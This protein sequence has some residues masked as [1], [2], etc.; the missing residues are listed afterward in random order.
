MTKKFKSLSDVLKFYNI[1][2]FEANFVIVKTET[3]HEVMQQDI[4]FT[5]KEIPYDISE[6]AI[7][8]NLIYPL[9]KEAWKL[10]ANVLMLWS[11]QALED[12]TGNIRIPDYLISKR[13]SLGKIIFDF[14]LL[15]V[16]EAKKDNFSLGWTQC[17][18]D[19]IKI[20][21]LNKNDNIDIYGLV[22]N[23][24][25]WE[26]AKLSNQQF[27]VYNKRFFIEELETLFNMLV[28]VLELCKQ[29]LIDLNLR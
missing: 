9:L 16:I 29:Q 18:L 28:S 26:V 4:M 7:C 25:I 22:S 21:Q 24:K 1:H 13:S 12:D 23:G 15:A 8:E 14:P 20:Q 27:I 6:A 5:L 2:Y 10:Y 11:H 17:S 19:M 3:L